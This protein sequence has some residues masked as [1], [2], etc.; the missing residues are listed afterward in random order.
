MKRHKKVVAFGSLREDILIPWDFSLPAL[1]SE[2]EI[3]GYRSVIGGSVHNTCLFLA[4]YSDK[5]EVTLCV[6][7]CEELIGKARKRE[8]KSN[9]Q[10]LSAG[11]PVKLH[12][13]SIIG[14]RENGEKSMISYNG[15]PDTDMMIDLAEQHMCEADILYTSFY[16]VN[17]DDHVKISRLF[18]SC[19][20]NEKTV[21]IDLC[22]LLKELDRKIIFRI[23]SFVTV[24]SGNEE[25]YQELYRILK[26]KKAE[27]IFDM[28]QNVQFL[29]IKR[30]SKGADIL[31]RCKEG[32]PGRYER[33]IDEAVKAQ[34]TTGCGDVFNGGVILG[35]LWEW[36]CRQILD[37]AVEE[38]K[39]F[40][41]GDKRWIIG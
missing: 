7:S 23:V 36:D 1:A 10:I 40:A 39:K 17:A 28:F 22:P 33:N 4:G 12:P 18:E 2:V 20:K 37:K 38:S 32:K 6:P 16:E 29:F 34:N 15:R 24:L 8:K 31:K 3:D 41:E 21:M 30:G 13:I 19:I 11:P 26:V 5:T 25:E 27:D 35:L 14:V 9:Y